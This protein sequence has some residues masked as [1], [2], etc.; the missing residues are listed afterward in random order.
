MHELINMLFLTVGITECICMLV[1]GFVLTPDPQLLRSPPSTFQGKKKKKL[2]SSHKKGM[3]CV[4]SLRRKMRPS[5]KNKRLD[6]T[7]SQIASGHLLK[8]HDINTTIFTPCKQQCDIKTTTPI[9]IGLHRFFFSFSSAAFVI[10]SLLNAS[11]IFYASSF[12][13]ATRLSRNSPSG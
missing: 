12:K 10:P 13:V 5:A 7:F 8:Q 1:R 2:C 4:L 11:S 9:R 3:L 6:S